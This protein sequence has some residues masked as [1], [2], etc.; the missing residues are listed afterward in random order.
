VHQREPLAAREGGGVLDVGH[1][2]A[3]LL[4]QCQAPEMNACAKGESGAQVQRCASVAWSAGKKLSSRISSAVTSC[5]VP[6]VV[7]M[8]K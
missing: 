6:T 4:G 5:G 7:T 2:L 1:G 8:E 3:K